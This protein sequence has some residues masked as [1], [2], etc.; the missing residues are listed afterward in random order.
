VTPWF[1]LFPV[2]NVAWQVA[3]Q[4]GG[5]VL[6]GWGQ[7]IGFAGYFLWMAL[8]GLALAFGRREPVGNPATPRA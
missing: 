6:P 4:A 7:R 5:L 8:A 2:T 1:V 3:W